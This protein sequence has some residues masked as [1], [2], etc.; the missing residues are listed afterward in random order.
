MA[1][2]KPINKK[3]KVTEIPTDKEKKYKWLEDYQDMF[4]FDLKPISDGGLHKLASEIV[5]WAQNDEAALQV[6]AFLRKKGI[7]RDAYYS[8]VNKYP[9]M[10]RANDSVLWAIG[11]RREMKGMTRELD[12]GM[13]K[14]MMPH[15]DPAWMNI[16][17]LQSQLKDAQSA[18]LGLRVVEIP[19]FEDVK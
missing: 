18:S 12:P 10:K 9:V 17:K 16:L 11:D 13:I 1:S 3:Q 8:W 14:W 5:H 15:Y 6:G 4:T 19:A 7:P 2:K